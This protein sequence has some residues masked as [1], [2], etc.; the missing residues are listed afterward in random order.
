MI[1]ENFYHTFLSWLASQLAPKNWLW[2]LTLVAIAIS[3]FLAFPPYALLAD[4]LRDNGV[5]LDAWLFIQNQAQD[6]FHPSGMEHDVRRENMIFRWTLPALSF[7]THHNVLL[8]VIIQGIL[9]VLF[10]K[11]IGDYIFSIS[12]DKIVTALFL[13]SLANTF[14]CVWSFADIH[15]YGDG[16][17]YFFLL[18]ALLN[19][20]GIIIF[21]S[22]QIAFFTD[23]RA[24]VA[25]GYL[26]LWWMVTKAYEKNDFSF[27]ALL[28]SA[29]TGESLFVWIAWVVYFAIREYVQSRYFP[30]HSYSTI[31]TPVLFAN[32][33]RNGLGSSIWGAFEGIW[34]ILAAATVVLWVSRRY[35]LLLA[36]FVGF[37]VLVATGIYVHDIDRAL[38][39]G[40]PFILAAMYI[41]IKSESYPTIKI[42]LFFTMIICVGH[43]Q[44][45]YMGYNKI[46]WLEPLPMKIL[47]YIDRHL[48]WN[49]F[50]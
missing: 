28:K 5:K 40:F 34:L 8:I 37:S 11:K 15:G 4:H 49:F 50:V 12:G 14:V 17:A 47:M 2:K 9:A 13:L 27:S 38:A 18:M 19:R 45:F 35:W 26:V 32:A 43:P 44:V 21:L 20:N 1:L 41:L 29:F 31:G 39:Y 42:L 10:L 30:H 33:H 7:L 25:G 16:I 22:L 24:V 46:L 23:E 36:L 3:L 48:H 6:L